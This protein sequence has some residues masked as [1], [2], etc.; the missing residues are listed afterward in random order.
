MFTKYLQD[1]FNVPLIIHLSDDEKFLFKDD[2]SLEDVEKLALENI[3]DI[4][5][6]GFDPEKTLILMST[7]H[8]FKFIYL[9]LL[10]NRQSLHGIY[11]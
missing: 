3:K 5:A 1:A 10:K 4:I 7:I 6:I 8:F 11:V 2:L 9:C